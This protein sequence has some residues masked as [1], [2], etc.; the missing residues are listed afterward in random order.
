M[1]WSILF[2]YYALSEADE[3]DGDR[4]CDSDIDDE[5]EQRLL[6]LMEHGRPTLG[7]R[8]CS[9]ARRC[10]LGWLLVGDASAY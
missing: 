3:S 2:P 6:Q 10:C 4:D 9:L 7:S 5:L 8:V 1:N